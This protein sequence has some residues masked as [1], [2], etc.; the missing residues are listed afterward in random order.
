ME[1]RAGDFG[2]LFFKDDCLRRSRALIEQAVWR[3]W[4]QLMGKVEGISS[5]VD[6]LR[7]VSR[8]TL[9]LSTG[10]CRPALRIQIKGPVASLA[11]FFAR[12]DESPFLDQWT[13]ST[14]KSVPFSVIQK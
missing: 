10:V 3:R 2:Y 11:L 13:L 5:P 1:Q 4:S 12:L 14:A 9:D 6:L 7:T 8:K